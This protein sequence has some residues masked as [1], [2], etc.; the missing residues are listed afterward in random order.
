[1]KGTNSQEECKGPQEQA[2]LPGSFGKMLQSTETRAI[3][4]TVSS[5]TGTWMDAKQRTKT[6][7]MHLGE[8]LF[9][10]LPKAMDS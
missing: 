2:A 7:K 1:M 9:V 8:H 6:G 4:V 10:F 3:D 5:E